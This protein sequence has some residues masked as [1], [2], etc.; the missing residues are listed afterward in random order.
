MSTPI[1]TGGGA[2]GL[3]ID[4]APVPSNLA[5]QTGTKADSKSTPS[6]P[7]LSTAPTVSS[8][9]EFD[10]SYNI[11]DYDDEKGKGPPPGWP[12]LAKLIAIHP[13]FEAFP[14]FTELNVKSLFYYQAELVKLQ[15]KLREIEWRDYRDQSRNGIQHSFAAR[16]DFLLQP[17]GNEDRREQ[18]ELI[19][20]IRKT[21][22]DYSMCYNFSA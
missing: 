8:L 21:L 12:Q 10:E 13:E 11:L 19:Q 2:P 6:N 17:Y 3:E 18:W 4:P 7:I 9:S 22:K 20:Q 15:D 16:A 5:P 14:A 1:E